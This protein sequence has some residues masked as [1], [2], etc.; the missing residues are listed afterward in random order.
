MP[1]S[2]GDVDPSLAPLVDRAVRRTLADAETLVV[3]G[4]E[5]TGLV[6]LVEGRLDVVIQRGDRRIVL[7]TLRPGDIAGEATLGGGGRAATALV[8]SGAAVVDVVPRAAAREAVDADPRLAATVAA[9]ARDRSD[10]AALTL[11]L[12]DMLSDDGGALAHPA[13]V[14]GRLPLRRVTA[15]EVLLREGERGDEAMLVVAGRLRVEQVGDDGPRV[16]ARPGR[17]DVVGE[18]GLLDRAERTATVTAARDSVVAVI[19]RARFVDLAREHPRVVLALTEQI[20]ARATGPAA[21]DRPTVTSL[22]VV[23]L[24]PLL[25]TRVLTART[26]AA[27]RPFGSVSTVT[28]ASVDRALGVPGASTGAPDHPGSARVEQH[29]HDEENAHDLLL[30]E[31]GR[32]PDAWTRRAVRAADRVVALLSADP[33]DDERDRTRALLAD[34]P[35]GTTTVAVLVHPADVDRPT[36]SALVRDDLGV[37]EVLHVRR[38]SAADLA[39][40]ARLNA[41]RGVA[42]VLGGGGAR[43]H[44]HIGVRRALAELGVPVDLVVGSS[45]GAPIAGGIACGVGVDEMI[46]VAQRLFED[47]LD[48]TL[49]VVS[50]IKGER[51]AAAIGAQFDGWDFED[52]WIPFR[53]VVTNLTTSRTE[54]AARGAITPMIRASVSIPGVMPPV[55]RGDDLLVDGGLLDNL[56]VGVAAADGRCD[57]IVAVDV[58]PPHGPQA[59]DDYGLSVSGWRA[60][61]SSLGRDA[62]SYPGLT[63]VLMRSMLVG[64]MANR[65]RSLAAAGVDLLLELRIR[66]V[67]LLEFEK[68]RTAA[69]QGHDLAR[70]L[71]ERWIATARPPAVAAPPD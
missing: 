7:D 51:I 67:G 35:A 12:A 21:H 15:G 69:E 1:S 55:P 3:A 50:L 38:S 58:A 25:D 16:L 68:V 17:G 29:V 24:T 47:L 70:P 41:G 49:P 63:A 4:A 9:A 13:D 32:E 20:V 60:L 45:I 66:G 6:V 28:A 53:C 64:A 39:R 37:D 42:L 18:R 5:P 26:A 56:P 59:R 31:L 2:T 52:T 48:Y 19:D 34:V 40:V 65:G 43:G 14:A 27:L 10:R 33:D 54:T 71:V 23:S 57:T 44:A 11:V 46:P 22:A 36:G 62:A 30:L 8:A 61:R